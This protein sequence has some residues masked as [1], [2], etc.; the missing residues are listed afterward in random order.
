MVEEQEPLEVVASYSGEVAS[1]SMQVPPCPAVFVL[2][3]LG[4]LSFLPGD[5]NG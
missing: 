2:G 5:M 4:D 1:S 3:D